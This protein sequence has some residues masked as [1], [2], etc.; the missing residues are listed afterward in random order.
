M[1]TNGFGEN[2]GK[3]NF[4]CNLEMNDPGEKEIELKFPY[5]GTYCFKDIRIVSQPM[6]N[7][8]K[9]VEKLEDGIE[10]YVHADG[11]KVKA[12]LKLSEPR[13][14]CW[15][16]PFEKGWSAVVDGKKADLMRA[17]IMYMALPL[18]E[19]EHEIELHYSNP[20]IR[21][22]IIISIIG[23]LGMLICIIENYIKKR[24]I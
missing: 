15:A 3:N 12:S 2:N 14:I 16:V 24:K 7:V 9:N 21:G 22:G 17:N 18:K 13:L 19:G 20:F 4:L 5:T 6:V 10:G 23:I 11:N 1:N 8:I